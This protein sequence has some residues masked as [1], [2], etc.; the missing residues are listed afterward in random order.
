MNELAA[1]VQ[2]DTVADHVE[3]LLME[4]VQAGNIT[5]GQII[6]VGTSTSEVI[7]SRIGTAG[8]IQA[9]EQIYQGVERARGRVGFYVAF[10]C[11]EHLNRALLVERELLL[12]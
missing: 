1:E 11:C 3:S 5:A 2:W 7:G 9:A 8:S 10:Q 4:L 12:N 6:V